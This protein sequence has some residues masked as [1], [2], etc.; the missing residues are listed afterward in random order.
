M[1]ATTPSDILEF[2]QEAYHR[3]YDSAFWMRDEKLMDERQEILSQTGVTAQDV[4]LEAVLPY[5]STVSVAEACERAGLPEAVSDHLG[6]VVFGGD[7]ALR[8]HQA[9]SLETSLADNSAKQRNVVVTSGTGSGKTES[10]LL[11]VIA[12]LLSE[13]IGAAPDGE[14]RQWWKEVWSDSSP[15]QGL[16]SGVRGVKPAIRALLLYPTNALVE[17]QICRI[18]RAAFRAQLIH[19]KP[20]FYFGRYTGA[21]P[22]GTYFPEGA[23]DAN[24]RKRVKSLARE[25]GELAREADRL[26]RRPDELRGQFPD[27]LCGEML[28][29]WD[30]LEAPPDIFITNVAMLNIM[31]MRGLETSI[32]EQTK[33]WLAESE[34]HHFSLIIDELHGYRGTAGTEVALVIR[35][36]LAR[37]GLEPDSPQLRCLGTSASLDGEEGLK[38]LEEFFG[39]S[40]ETFK[41]YPG[42]PLRPAVELPVDR[43]LLKGKVEAINSGDQEATRELV[44]KLSPRRALGSACLAAGERGDGRIVPATLDEVRE[45][46]LGPTGTVAELD[47]IC[48]AADAEP[49]ES[50]RAPQPSF[51]AHL[52]LRQIQGMWACSNPECTEVDDGYQFEERQVG[53]LYRL[54]TLKCSCGGQV[55]EL[56]YCYD[57][58]ELYLGGYVTKPANGGDGTM[59]LESGPTDL[60]TVAPTLVNEREHGQFAWYWP[61]KFHDPSEIS[62][63]SHTI[64]GTRMTRTF[65]FHPA[66]YTPLDGRLVMASPLD[67]PT[68]TMLAIPPD[69][70]APAVPEKCPAC[71]SEKRQQ[72]LRAFFAGRRVESSIRAFR[73]GLNA[74]TQLIADRAADSVGAGDGAAQMIVFTDSRDDAADVAGGL[75]LN[76]FR[77]LVRQLVVAVLND[78]GA[79][80]L[81]DIQEVARATVAGKPLSAVQSRLKE[82]IESRDARF[83]PAFLAEAF[84]A[85]SEAHAAT[86]SSYEEEYLSK[87]TLAWPALIAGVA[88]RMRALGVN[89]SGP[90]ASRQRP[91]GE[92]WWRYFDETRPEG[93]DPIDPAA[94]R[95][96]RD[97]IDQAIANHVAGALFDAGGR[98]LESLGIAFVAP[99]GKHGAALGVSNDVASGILA[100]VV[101]I[102]GQGRRYE[103]S[104][105]SASEATPARVKKYLGRVADRLGRTYGEIESSVFRALEDAGVVRRTW[106]ILTSRVAGL[107][108]ELVPVKPGTLQQ[109]ARCSR[110]T[111]CLPVHACTSAHC[112]SRD[113][114]LLGV[115]E[116]GTDDYYRWLAAMP[117][118]RLHVEELT[119]QTKPLSEQRRRQRL[120]KKAFLDGEAELSHGIDVLSV[121]T[122]MEVGVDIGSLEL[123]MMANVPPQRFNY[124]Q[125]VGRAGRAGQSFSYAV[126]VC[127][128]GSHDDFYYNHSDRITG[129]K[130]PQPYLDLSR[131]EVITRVVSAELLRRAF[132]SLDPPPS[133]SGASVHGAFGAADAWRCTYKAPVADWLSSAPDVDTVVDRLCAYAPVATEAV[134][135]LK[136]FCRVG[137][138]EKISDIASDSRYIQQELSERLATAAVLPMF[139]F[140]TQSRSLF[141]FVENVPVD[142]QVVSDRPLDHAIWAFSPGAEVPKDK[143]IH[144]ACGFEYKMDMGG[145]IVH[146][147]D[148]L[149]PPLAFSRCVDPGCMAF[150]QGA[151]ETCGTC[152][153]PCE[154]FDLYQ[155]KGFRTTGTPRDYDGQR[156]RGPVLPPPVLAF[157]P[158]YDSGL[159]LGP[160]RIALASDRPIA[161]IND[162]RGELFEFKRYHNSLV[163]TD[164]SLY[165]RP[166][167]W[168]SRVGDQPESRGAIGAVF[169]TDV[170][171]LVID[172]A[173]GVGNNGLLD[174]D[175]QSSAAAAI[176]SF[177]Q[178]LRKAATVALDVDPAELRTGTQRYRAP[179]CVTH[180]VFLADSLPNGAGYTRHLYDAPYLQEVLRTHY[181]TVS[182]SWTTPHHLDCDSSCPDCMRTY[183]NRFVHAAL[184]WR[185]A[186]DVAELVL[187]IPLDTGRWLRDGMDIATTFARICGTGGVP[188]RV[189]DAATLPA[190]I[191]G[192]ELALV[193]C[194]PLW[195]PREGLANDLQLNAKL[196]LQAR[197]GIGLA[198]EFVDIRSLVRQPQLYVPAMYTPA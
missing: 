50:Y 171:S 132:L 158:D 82:E 37:L 78:S 14:I 52:F 7:F 41:V 92:P 133:G 101:R 135:A 154:P 155:P 27:P 88:T 97:E 26:R 186:L 145:R 89:P 67:V 13:R 94:A 73:T 99:T 6:R 167:P 38:Y 159:E 9:Q 51:R 121:T 129:D 163:V 18:R 55:L 40:R 189:Q 80:T 79:T 139:G 48:R 69:T 153:Q 32:F 4:R 62:T 177:S 1:T 176:T 35:N 17:D 74:T 106:V 119:G 122:T 91:G 130:P 23:L 116:G 102:L 195:H 70:R 117:G 196:E 151:V 45:A 44:T 33:A 64:P 8:S 127:R 77:S 43:G 149:G 57:C 3:Y 165:E 148:P 22:G 76:H 34:D 126:T 96:P 10:F 157:Q 197:F 137:L 107:P 15:W 61:G 11:P 175:E 131:P 84:G 178:F 194:H 104:S 68:G 192:E 182:A 170:L 103:G 39:V 161:L 28:T 166:P 128:A 198:C 42:E 184:D 168:F 105:S 185:L 190:I 143:Q 160:A 138:A 114:S 141:R 110:I 36:L 125:R 142:Q 58:G 75:E 100:N 83:W 146:D 180:Q 111:A 21:T 56:L 66:V 174:V 24:G 93:V 134:S 90:D 144:T 188:P 81:D 172:R 140:P 123:V 147:D 47:A 95:G 113:F 63:W 16:R 115:G 31:L 5:P 49:L 112:E 179:S 59:F 156:Q 86:R 29:R 12:R 136:A 193:L 72:N 183:D 60:A 109:C 25:I 30:M 98:D 187:G 152:G 19:G 87:P 108:L 46:L 20:L 120:F 124:Q 191:K 65:S 54:P 164:E 150:Q 118:Q 71:L 181:D 173:V 2:I 169:Q 162:N 85:D 53:K